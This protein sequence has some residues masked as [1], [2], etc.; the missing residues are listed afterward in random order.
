M[1]YLWIIIIVIIIILGV[2][3]FE[4]EA[5]DEH[6]GNYK[7]PKMSEKVKNKLKIIYKPHNERLFEFLGKLLVY[8]FILWFVLERIYLF[9]II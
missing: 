1:H 5:E 6:I 2:E 8:W 3:P 7:K 4:F 9:F